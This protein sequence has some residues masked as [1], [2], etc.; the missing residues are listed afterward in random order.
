MKTS[1]ELKSLFQNAGSDFFDRNSREGSKLERASRDAALESKQVEITDSARFLVRITS[2][3]KRL[4]DEDNLAGKYHCDCLR[5]AGIIPDDS[6]NKTHIE[7][8]QRK[9]KKG[10]EERTLIEVFI[11]NELDK[12]MNADTPRTSEAAGLPCND[13]QKTAESL[14]DCS[15][16]LERELAAANDHLG[17]LSVHTHGEDCQRPA[18]VLRR[19]NDRL[20]EALVAALEWADMEIGKCTKPNPITRAL[21]I[22]RNKHPKKPL[23]ASDGVG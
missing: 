9:A 17:G 23:A 20:T 5:Y 2:I 13:W 14:F 3:R 4:L 12:A 8:R 15:A 7:T 11:I 16:K 10:E 1:H 18:C 22:Y 6:P 19:E 21:S